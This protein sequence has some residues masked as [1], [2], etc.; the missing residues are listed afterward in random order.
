MKKHL[1]DIL[2]VI[3]IVLIYAD[4]ALYHDGLELLIRLSHFLVLGYVIF[5]LFQD[6]FRALKKAFERKLRPWL[7][8]NIYRRIRT[9][10]KR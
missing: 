4:S 2:I 7:K 9:Y 10:K 8:R 6:S 3:A 5:L 1:G